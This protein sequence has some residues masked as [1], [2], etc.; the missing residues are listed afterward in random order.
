VVRVDEAVFHHRDGRQ[1]PVSYVSSPIVEESAMTGTVTLFQD[2]TLRKEMEKTLVRS[3]TMSALGGM[4]AGVAHEINTPVGV[5]VTS[6]SYLESKTRELL[7][8]VA[9]NKLSRSALDRYLELSSESSAII[10]S[11]LQRAGRLIKSFKQIAADQASEQR[12][13]FNLKS[14]MDDVV[15]TL[16]PELKKTQLNVV[17]DCPDDIELDSYPGALSQV[18][19]NLIMNSVIHGY[20]PDDA[21]QLG[22]EIED[23]ET[24][25][26]I[27]YQDDGKGISAE[28]LKDVFAPFFTTR[29]GQ[30]SSGLG[31]HI[32]HNLVYTVLRGTIS[33]ASRLNE[34]VR[35]ILILPKAPQ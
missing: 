33:A 28:H 30:G 5:S 25:V 1:I 12:S 6:A 22:F 15:L 26:R 11:N 19:T 7:Q 27:L 31:L 9:E 35:F 34:G 18:I 14:Y 16:R 10:L 29:R 13:R 21:G 3:E 24:S 32:T 8:L 23:E 17:I 2:I 20:G 4:V